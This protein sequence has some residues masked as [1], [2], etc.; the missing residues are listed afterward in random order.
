MTQ[1]SRSDMQTNKQ[2]N[3]HSGKKKKPTHTPP[4]VTHAEEA[5]V[6]NTHTHTRSHVHTNS[7][8]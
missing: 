7:K 4:A 2:T 6:V 5:R 8:L 3:K 1:I